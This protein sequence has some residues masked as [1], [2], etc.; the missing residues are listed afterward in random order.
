V[1]TRFQKAA[2]DFTAHKSRTMLVILAIFFGVF[3]TGLVLNLYGMV[4][5][6][7]NS[8]YMATN[9]HS[10]CIGVPA[11]DE[12]LLAALAKRDGIEDVEA[13]RTVRARIE[14]G[15]DTYLSSSS[16]LHVIEDFHTVRVD[17]FTNVDSDPPSEGFAPKLGEILIEKESVTDCGVGD[18]INL[19][20]SRNKPQKLRVAGKV[21]A[22]GLEPAWMENAVY[23]F[24]SPETLELLG[25]PME[26]YNLLFVVSEA[27]RFDEA[28]IRD[29]AFGIRDW[30]NDN[31][32]S[33]GSVSV[34]TP[35]KHP[36]GDQTNALLFLF[37]VFCVLSL[38]LSGVLVFHMIT[39]MLSGQ[40]RQIAVMKAVGARRGQI[41]MIYYLLVVLSGMIALV[42]ALP[43]AAVSARAF[44]DICASMLNFSVA[45]Y[46]IPWWPYLLQIVAGLLIPALAAT[47]P[48][49]RGTRITV[50]EGLR[51]YGTRKNQFGAARFERLLGK[52]R[53]ASPTLLSLRN[54][55]RRR[56]RL[57]L[58]VATLAV[59]GAVLIVSLNVNASIGHTLD[60]AMSAL[61][62]DIRYSFSAAYPEEDVKAAIERVPGVSK[63]EMETGAMSAMVYQDGTES[64][65][66]QLAAVNSQSE[67]LRLPVMS[68][69][70][71]EPNDTNAVV[72]NHIYADKEPSVMIGDTITVKCNGISS[73][74]VVSGIVKEAGAGAKAYVSFDFYQRLY[75]QR[76]YASAVNIAIDEQTPEKRRAIAAQIEKSLR[77]A[78]IDV[79][80][81]GNFEDT[82]KMFVNHL[83]I[84]AGFLTAASVLVIIV[85]VMG[86]ISS[87][88]INVM[89]RV[90]EIGIMRAYGATSQNI[91]SIIVSEGAF[92]GLLSGA[93]SSILSLPLTH[94]VGNG[95]GKIFL[96]TPLENVLNP[97][98]YTL[99]LL[100]GMAITAFVG[101][102][103][104][105]KVSEIPVNEIL[106]YE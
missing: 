40:V 104:A 100:I 19:K 89:E 35:G 44:L 68:G 14:T 42:F 55:F 71:L 73:P 58:T 51:D 18:T 61:S 87:T 47:P 79:M 88:G 72:L 56:G 4:P 50:H 8:S 49:V 36:H 90:R 3:G 46:G 7:M 38:V 1:K 92:I 98:G 33:A 96:Q 21:H 67:M 17:T 76:G 77:S 85:G 37:Q 93:I 74:W 91:L 54:T 59:G 16:Y 5:R 2:R 105:L 26:N 52:I 13:R 15:E 66:F 39:A 29:V 10:F 106:N 80:I 94:L 43:L 86:L 57:F 63:I 30:L 99:W 97:L 28:A 12:S 83:A 27:I 53:L 48:I 102:G 82:K 70:W 69:R 101:F 65:P 95:V 31:G 75:A 25:S 60:K 45:S 32:Y 62:Y 6:E 64:N 81:S 11:C 9:P 24:I 22:P 34:P 84:I 78:E 20:I 103:A 23:G 41:A